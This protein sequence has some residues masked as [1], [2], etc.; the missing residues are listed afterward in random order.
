MEKI[1]SFKVDHMRLVP[2]IYV[3]RVDDINGSPVTTYDIRVKRPNFEE[4]MT[5]EIA[6]TI[7]HFGAM[8]LRNHP[9][10]KNNI[11]GWFPMGCLT[12]FCLV[13]DGRPETSVIAELVLSM[14]KFIV[15]YR[16]N[17]ASMGFDP[18]SCGNYRLN[19][20][21]GAQ[22]LAANFL[23]LNDTFG[24]LKFVYPTAENAP[25][26]AISSKING[27]DEFAR[28]IRNAHNIARHIN[29]NYD[30]KVKLRKIRSLKVKPLKIY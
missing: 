5:P 26:I 28:A 7:E 6:H 17:L 2:G 8:Y 24:L 14:M 19:D 4:P 16:G 30:D 22:T 13:Y 18:E 9:Q 23:V 11:I 25:E 1:P 10:F 27:E 15:E 20:L 12:G 21:N 3:S 29:V